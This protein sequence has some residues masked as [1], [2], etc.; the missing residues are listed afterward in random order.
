MALKSG[1]SK[2]EENKKATPAKT[3]VKK[4]VVKK[5]EP[6]YNYTKKF[7]ESKKKIEKN[8]NQNKLE[9]D[10][11]VKN[12]EGKVAVK[13]YEKKFIPADKT[14]TKAMVVDSK[15]KTVKVASSKSGVKTGNE[16]L[17]N[18]YKRDST[19]TMKRRENN[20]NFVRVNTNTKPQ[21]TEKDLKSLKNLKKVSFKLSS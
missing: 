3:T 10:G 15:G 11:V 14:R 4:A 6:D 20:A 5:E 2:E 16:R 8:V 21:L 19:E 18:E 17:Y 7:S 13:P 12:K 1:K 9:K